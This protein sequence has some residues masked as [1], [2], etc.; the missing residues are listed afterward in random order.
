MTKSNLITVNPKIRE[1]G[2]KN[3]NIS[4][5]NNSLEDLEYAF[6]R[7]EKLFNKIKSN[8]I[9]NNNSKII[10]KIYNSYLKIQSDQNLNQDDLILKKHENVEL[11]KISENNLERYFVYRYKF[12]IYPKIKKIDYY[13]PCVQ[14]EP[15]SICNYRC[16]M[17]YQADKTFSNKSNG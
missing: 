4:L 15:T 6:S 2:F 8:K 16:I 3:E 7:I 11:K 14:I 9:T 1:K 13:P 5:K 12:N 10:S 17:C